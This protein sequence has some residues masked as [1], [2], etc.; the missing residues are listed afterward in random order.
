[1][2]MRLWIIVWEFLHNLS[3]R[4]KRI[5]SACDLSV[6][7]SCE[8]YSSTWIFLCCKWGQEIQS[9]FDEKVLDEATYVW[10]HL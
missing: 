4:I 5:Y 10:P 7:I 8:T 2:K 6:D 9:L 3:L 1:M